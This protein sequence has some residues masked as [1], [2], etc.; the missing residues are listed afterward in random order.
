MAL[1]SE[2]EGKSWGQDKLGSNVLNF[3][4]NWHDDHIMRWINNFVR[5]TGENTKAN[6]DRQKIK[7]TGTLKRSLYWQ[8]FA[9]SNGDEQVFRARYIYYAKFVE[10]ALGKGDPYN[11][12]VPNIPGKQWQPIPV[13]TRRRKG[14]PHVVTEMR[15]QAKKFTSYARK[16][17][18]FTGTVM[19]IYAMGGN[20]EPSIRAAVNRA[21]FWESNKGKFDR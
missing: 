14:R 6:V 5:I 2:I 18:A 20:E 21:L 10:L 1:I 8:T 3:T 19:M 12:P 11:G 4:W 16:H 15:S 7:R 17:F 13:P 9:A